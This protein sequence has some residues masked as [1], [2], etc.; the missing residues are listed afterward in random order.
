MAELSMYKDVVVPLIST[1]LGGV[2]GVLGGLLV[3]YRSERFRKLANWEPYARDLWVRQVDLCSN[4]LTFSGG[5]LDAAIYCFDVF[6]ADKGAQTAA[7]SVLQK[8]LSDL[9]HLRGERLAICTP[10]LNQS[11]EALTSQLVVIL[12]QFAEGKLNQNL[13][14]NLPSLWFD[15]VD[16]V[17]TELR[18][19]RLDAEARAALEKASKAPSFNPSGNSTLPY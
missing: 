5:A 17:R 3:A 15:L 14:G 8:Q 16:D 9:G 13:S 7:S 6:N 4:L 12:Q 2:L 10:N 19:E 18:V 11:V 1:M